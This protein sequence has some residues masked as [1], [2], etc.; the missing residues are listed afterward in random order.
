MNSTAAFRLSTNTSFYLIS[1]AKHSFCL[2]M[3]FIC[4]SL[5]L[6]HFQSISSEPI[7]TTNMKKHEGDRSLDSIW[8]RPMF[9]GDFDEW[10]SEENNSNEL[11]KSFLDNEENTPPNRRSNFWKRANFWRKRANFWRRDTSA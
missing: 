11:S 9:Y 5:F 10:N 6:I 3:I 4:L 7:L 2:E 8:V 1:F